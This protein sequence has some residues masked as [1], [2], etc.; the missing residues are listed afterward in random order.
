MM[1]MLNSARGTVIVEIIT[2]EPENFLQILNSNGI[3]LKNIQHTDPLT[4]LFEQKRSDYKKMCSL[5]EKAGA[6]VKLIKKSGIYWGLKSLIGRPVL[7]TG[8]LLIFLLTLFLPTRILFVKIKGNESLPASLILEKAELCGISFGASRKAVRSESTK[9]QLLSFLPELRWVGVNTYGCVAVISVQEKPDYQLKSG[10]NTICHIVAAKDGIISEMTIFQGTGQCKVGQA[11]EKGQVLVSGYVDHGIS[12]EATSANAEIM[13]YTGNVLYMYTPTA[14]R[15]RD[16]QLAEKTQ[17]KLLIGK[18][19]INFSKDSGISDTECVRMYEERYL[20]LPGGFRLPI[21]LIRERTMPYSLES[22]VTLD[23][24]SYTWVE[25]VAKDYLHSQML[26]GE[27]LR[28]STLT[29]IVDDVHVLY[30]TY[31]CRELIGRIRSEEK[32]IADEQRN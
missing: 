20:T 2:A 32:L 19:L 3:V 16:K 17:Y 4:L 18:K 25:S 26:S 13:G 29:E 30:G 28:A 8:T 14:R 12:L 1:G 6:H 10:G 31:Q 22:D 23:P 11:V 27:I 24:S 21:A 9:N 7:I 5:A 15:V